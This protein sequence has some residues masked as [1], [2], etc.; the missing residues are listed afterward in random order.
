M[1]HR[2]CGFISSVG[3]P[4]CSWLA[5]QACVLTWARVFGTPEVVVVDSGTEFQGAL[6]DDMQNNCA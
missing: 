1:T 5:W 6:A 4:P 3:A 2:I